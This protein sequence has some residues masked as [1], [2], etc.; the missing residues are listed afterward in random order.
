M[1]VFGVG[2]VVGSFFIGFIVDMF[3][4]KAGCL[5]KIGTLITTLIFFNEFL[6]INDYNILTYLSSFMWGVQD[7]AVNTF[8]Q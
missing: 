7:G 5:V 1:S 4:S 2:E 8:I 6:I 3:G